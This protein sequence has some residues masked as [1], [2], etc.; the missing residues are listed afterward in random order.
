MSSSAKRAQR[1][2]DQIEGCVRARHSE[3]GRLRPPCRIALANRLHGPDQARPA[4]RPAAARRPRPPRRAP[5]RPA[6]GCRR[7]DRRRCRWPGESPKSRPAPPVRPPP[8]PTSSRGLK[9]SAA[10]CLR[11]AA[12]L[13]GL[14]HRGGGDRVQLLEPHLPGQ[15]AEAGERRA[16]SA[17]SPGRRAARLA[18]PRP[19]AAITFSLKSTDG[20][21]AAP[22]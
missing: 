14:A 22:P 3:A 21:R 20:M 9:P 4:A 8:R 16:A 2:A 15:Q 5:L 1:A 10:I 13:L 12:P 6:P 11:K 7:R 18:R 17:P 19:S